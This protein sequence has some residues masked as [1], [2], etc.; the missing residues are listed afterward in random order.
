MEIVAAAFILIFLVL[1]LAFIG[2]LWL[3][4]FLVIAVLAM[5]WVVGVVAAVV[6]VLTVFVSSL[7]WAIYEHLLERRRLEK[8]VGLDLLDDKSLQRF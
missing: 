7:V 2:T 6:F 5:I 1:A 8:L 4:C 3:A